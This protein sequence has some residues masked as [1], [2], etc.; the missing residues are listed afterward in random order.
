[1]GE[2]GRDPDL[3]ADPVVDFV[4]FVVDIGKNLYS[5][6]AS[7]DKGDAF[8]CQVD[9]LVPLRRVQEGAFEI[10]KT[11]DLGPFPFVET[12]IWKGPRRICDPK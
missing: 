4:D 9:G 10:V 2:A 11:F 1:M 12:I 6:G 5:G 8:A 3:V 7:S